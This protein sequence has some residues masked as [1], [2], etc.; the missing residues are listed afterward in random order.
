MYIYI[1]IYIKKHRQTRESIGSQIFCFF[2][3]VFFCFVFWVLVG[4]PKGS[5]FFL[6][7][8][9]VFLFCFFGFGWGTPMGSSIF[10]FLVLVSLFLVENPHGVM[11]VY[12]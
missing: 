2:G 10:V 6:G 11:Y 4:D 3:I 7:V 9:I 1:Y 5:D 8:G 12:I